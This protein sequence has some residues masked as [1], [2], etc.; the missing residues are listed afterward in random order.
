MHV[1]TVLDCGHKFVIELPD[2][3]F[4]RGNVIFGCPECGR[5]YRLYESGI[6][7]MYDS[8]PFRFLAIHY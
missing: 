6:I 4:E 1:D 3:V 7:R 5:R 8:K 2:D